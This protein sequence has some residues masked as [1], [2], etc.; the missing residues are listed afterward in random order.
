[1]TDKTID[2]KVKRILELDEQIKMLEEQ[3]DKLKGE[4]QYVMGDNE[5]LKTKK[6]IITWIHIAKQ[7]FDTKRFK[8]L[9]PDL[10]NIF[11]KVT[12]QRRFNIK[13]V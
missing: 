7:G 13:E 9:H 6:Y 4:V 10:Y 12:Q 5:E 2:T 1:M 8:E 11:A 3:R